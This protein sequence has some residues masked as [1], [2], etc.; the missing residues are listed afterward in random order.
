MEVERERCGHA[1]ETAEGNTVKKHEPPGIFVFEH[2]QVLVQRFAWRTL[3]AVF[4]ID[5]IDNQCDD[6][7][8]DSQTKDT[9]PAK[10]H[11]QPGRE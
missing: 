7:R 3:R 1:D 8:D 6:Q 9:V 4:R 10:E 11:G 2:V 5:G